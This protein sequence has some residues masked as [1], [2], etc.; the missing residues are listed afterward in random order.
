M[1]TFQVR[2]GGVW[3]DVSKF[4]LEEMPAIDRV[5]VNWYE[6]PPRIA[7]QEPADRR[8]TRRGRPE[9]DSRHAATSFTMLTCLANTAYFLMLCAFVTRDILYLR[10]LLV[11]A[12]ALVVFYTWRTG[13]PVIAAWNIVFVG[14]NSVMAVQILRE[15]RAVVLPAEL[16]DLYARSVRST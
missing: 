11:M 15:R 14:I 1:I 9:R 12:Q 3:A 8:P 2:F 6:R 10:G 4:T 13:V 16:T 5:L 7:L